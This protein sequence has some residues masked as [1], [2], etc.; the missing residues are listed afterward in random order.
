[1]KIGVLASMVVLAACAPR[2]DAEEAN[3]SSAPSGASVAED[4]V[5]DRVRLYALD[6][7]RISM[8]DLSLFSVEG[9]YEGR[10]NEAADMCFLIRHPKGDLLW[11]AGLNDSLH[12][13]ESGVEFGPF[14]L[15]VPNTLAA[16]L[17]TIGLSAADIEFFSISH[18]HFDHV[19][20]ADQLA[21]STFIINSLE[22]EYMFRDE[23][24]ADAESFALVAPL[25]DAATIEFN[26]DYDVFGDRSV[27]IIATPG[28]TPGHGALLVNLESAGAVLLSG[29]LYHL[30]EAREKRTVPT[31][32]VDKDQTLRSMDKFEALAAEENA[33]VI[34]QH[35]LEHMEALPR[36]PAFL[37]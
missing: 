21:G 37:D 18:S 11:D 30:K 12:E 35:S 9:A 22:R 6:C 8:N 17:D 32:N 34:I 31:F 5:V 2:E 3:A 14:H 15:S 33:R 23:V 36:P 27:M 7:G 10:E 13:A 16:Q 28:H 1:M 20:N 25:E 19:G 26:G 4:G 24:R 29:D